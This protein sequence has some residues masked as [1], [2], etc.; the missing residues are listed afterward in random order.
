MSV[1]LT[2]RPK[3][4]AG[5][6]LWPL[7]VL[8]AVLAAFP[9]L[10]ANPFFINIGIDVCVSAM[11][12]VGLNLLAGHAGQISLGHAGFYGLGAY[13]AA[14]LT[15]RAGLPPL[16]AVLV[17]ALAVGLLAYVAGRPILRLRGH[18]LAVATLGLGVIISIVL[19]REVW[20]TAGPDGL[21]I[22]AITMFGTRLR[23]QPLWYGVAATAL[24]ATVW[25]AENLIHSPAGRALA[26][27]NSSEIAAATA[28]IDV[29]R[30]KVLV[31]TF[32]AIIACLAGAIFM[33]AGRFVTPA[34]ASFLKSVEFVTMIVLGGLASSYGAIVGAAV[35]TAL[36]QIFAPLADYTTIMLG[37]VLVLMM[38][39]LPRGVLPTLTA[40]LRRAR[41]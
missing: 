33:F 29:P 27:L 35:L 24:V 17:T 23:S 39:F 22:P 31:F 38:I 11:V 19:N 16:L 12:C 1:S 36:P 32:S 13:G 8:A 37:L 6:R 15:T 3:V 25:L 28:G 26:A 18:Y 21:S 34:D 30:A 40:R 20:L 7:L 5:A 41:A 4:R 14:L 9:L 2:Q 10:L